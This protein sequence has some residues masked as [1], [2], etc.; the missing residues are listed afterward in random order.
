MKKTL[1]RFSPDI[2]L[3]KFFA[4]LFFFGTNP[5]KTKLFKSKPESWRLGI[6][7]DGPGT[8]VIKILFLIKFF[9]NLYPGSDINGDPASEIKAI[10]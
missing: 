1:V 5:K 2:F 9:T 10:T 7:D 4:E 3:A 8:V 6:I